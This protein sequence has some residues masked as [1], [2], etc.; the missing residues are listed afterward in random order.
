MAKTQF[1]KR[2]RL[3]NPFIKVQ[4]CIIFLVLILLLSPVFVSA[5]NF[6]NVKGN[7]II[8]DTTSKYGKIDIKDWFGLLD[9]ATLELKENTDTCGNDC[10][11]RTEIIM[12]Q[13]GVL[14]DGVKFQER[15]WDNTWYPTTIDYKFYIKTGGTEWKVDDF[16]TE[17]SK[18][19]TN[20][21]NGTNKP[22]CVQVKSG[23]HREDDYTWEEY[24]TG[25]EVK[26]GT[27][28]IKLEGTRTSSKWIDWIITS[29][30][31]ELDFWYTWGEY[32]SSF[33]TSGK[34]SASGGVGINGS[35]I[36][37]TIADAYQMY[38][39]SGNFIKTWSATEP[40]G[41]DAGTTANATNWFIID[42]QP[43][44]G[45]IYKY[46]LSLNFISSCT[47]ADAGTYFG[48]AVNGSNF[49]VVDI[50]GREIVE[51]DLSCNTL[52]TY[53][54]A[55]TGELF[56]IAMN[57]S[58]VFV[59]DRGNGGLVYR[60][61]FA[62][63]RLGS[64][65]FTPTPASDIYAAGLGLYGEYLYISHNPDTEVY[66]FYNAPVAPDVSVVT[67]TLNSPVDYY[68]TTSNLITFNC[69]AITDGVGGAELSNITL[70]IDSVLNETKTISGV[71]YTET[72]TKN[73]PDGIYDWNCLAYDDSGS[74]DWG[75]NRSLSIDTLPP[76]IVINS[77]KKLDD[78]GYIGK[79]ETLNW[80][81]IHP[82]G[83]LDSLWYNYNGT[84]ISVYGLE[85]A[86]TFVLEDDFDLIFYA[87]D[88]GGNL[89]T[90]IYEWSYNVFRNSNTYTSSTIEEK[91]NSFL[92]NIT[93][94]SLN[95]NA[96]TGTL[97]YNNTNYSGTKTGSGDN[98][99]FTS[100]VY[101]PSVDSQQNV[102]FYWI[103]G[104]T[105]TTGTTNINSG[106]YNQTV[107]IIN[108]SLCG[109]PYN[110]PYL[111]FTCYDE[112]TYAH[113][114]CTVSLTFNY[115]QQDAGGSNIF[116]YNNLSSVDG[117]IDFCISPTD[118]TYTIDST[119]EYY[120]TGYAQRYYNFEGIE[121]TNATT[122]IGLYLLNTT[123]STSFIVK[124]QDQNYQP[125][126]NV[127]VYMQKYNTATGNWITVE[128]A[129]TND[130]GETINHIYTEDSIYRFKI[131]DNGELI[132]TTTGSVIACPATPCTV[133]ITIS[134]DITP[135]LPIFEDLDNLITSLVYSKT[136][137]DITYTYSDT[138]G[139]FSK[140][141]LYVIRSHPG[142]PNILFTC[143]DTSSSSTAV[144]TCDLTNQKNGTY[145]ATGFITRL[146]DSE[147]MVERKL[148]QKIK[149]IVG[150]IGLEGVLWS[151]FL[152]IGIIMLGVYRPSL[153][154]FFGFIGVLLLSWLQLIQIS[155]TAIVA[156]VGIG[157]ILLIEV[158]KQ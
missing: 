7:L 102:S 153:G 89:N 121:F 80:T 101:A 24:K 154:I 156:I 92:F 95:W 19:K 58:N 124:V 47:I 144:L 137:E 106:N 45:K 82:T 59:L 49:W 21:L 77:P 87:N 67:T 39:M 22:D 141:R 23:T 132:H 135:V 8:D 55:D 113:L 115:R 104:L 72:F 68:N 38:D 149:D 139:S 81:I 61:D 44:A 29:Q 131:Y 134:E 3:Q 13:D 53:A 136:T 71:D 33:D 120:A 62:G 52:H 74:F 90:T 96:I 126:T 116:N 5:A 66:K 130:D 51:L 147:R 118:E 16:K 103:I 91:Q 85:N 20:Y 119:M 27:Y 56:G 60:Y 157:I 148:I 128:I 30:G 145:I 129:T 37:V 140:A 158:G 35:V 142:E 34:G 152:L 125:K 99:L 109:H 32:I 6:D 4:G 93:Y 14:V 73:I 127:E 43:N 138:S 42:S 40:V 76:R 143:N 123:S 2:N 133:T 75:T 114:N 50:L 1:F 117:T 25:T 36:V 111:N 28:Y 65:S 64:F 12:Y 88:T 155:I 9:L 70:Y 151:M 17:C 146:S 41:K 46:D 79:T 18:G 100:N 98:L 69:S 83:V 150:I 11:M 110:I 48:L 54:I 108:M 31:Q 94:T 122:S 97:T 112:S 10:S 63:N 57:G 15:E 26:A 86:T 84:N 78:Y 105:N 107:N